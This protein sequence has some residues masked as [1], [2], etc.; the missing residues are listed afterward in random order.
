MAR[1]YQAT[2]W[3]I[4][5][6]TRLA[7]L[8]DDANLQEF[9]VETFS[10]DTNLL[11][12]YQPVAELPA[13]DAISFNRR[14]LELRRLAGKVASPHAF[15][16]TFPEPI[17]AL[18]A[19]SHGT[20]TIGTGVGRPWSERRQDD[21]P[22]VSASML[23]EAFESEVRVPIFGS[24]PEAWQTLG[25]AFTASAPASAAVA[26]NILQDGSPLTLLGFFA[27]FTVA[28]RIVLPAATAFG[29]VLEARIKEWGMSDRGTDKSSATSPDA[30]LIEELVRRARHGQEDEG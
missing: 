28:T 24:P 27:A 8:V 18:E 3:G 5:T 1:P 11:D 9:S 4:S 16:I 29:E 22:S 20:A 17:V 2:A 13:E 15:V 10:V 23:Y 12:R 26:V 6:V 14:L 25:Q 7:P 19:F 30:K 21:Y